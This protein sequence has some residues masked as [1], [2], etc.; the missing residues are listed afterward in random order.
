MPQIILEIFGT[1]SGP[2]ALKKGVRSKVSHIIF[3]GN[4]EHIC[5]SYGIQIRGQPKLRKR[6]IGF[7]KRQWWNY[8][9]RREHDRG[10]DRHGHTDSERLGKQ[11]TQIVS[12]KRDRRISDVQG[13]CVGYKNGDGKK[14]AE[15]D[16]VDRKNGMHP[17]SHEFTSTHCIARHAFYLRAEKRWNPNSVEN[18]TKISCNI[19]RD[20]AWIQMRFTATARKCSCG[21]VA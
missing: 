18:C 16:C 13:H 6:R 20:S 3:D 4:C 12:I 5:Q 7:G 21:Q 2:L 17:Y 19:V 15:A 8:E 1:L 14:D 11:W 10:Q 9:E